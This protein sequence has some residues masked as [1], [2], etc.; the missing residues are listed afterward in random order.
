[1]A[2]TEY[3]RPTISSEP[4]RPIPMANQGYPYNSIAS[5]RRYEELVYSIHKKKVENEKTWKELYDDIALM[6]GVG[7]KGR[8][9]VLYKDGII[10]GLIQCKKYE[11]RISKPDCL[12][13]ILKFVLYSF[14][15]PLVL[16][17]PNHFTYYFVVSEGFSG[18]AADYL[19]K[20]ND[21]II[22]EPEL[23]NW[24]NELKSKYN[25]SLGSLDYKTIYAD[26]LKKLAAIKVRKVVP[27]DLDIELSAPYC[28]SIIPIFFE[29][30]T[31]T[32]NSRIDQLIN[33]IRLGLLRQMI[34][35]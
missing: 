23:E 8:D 12:K 28:Q 32:D 18:P 29:V 16:P 6:Q 22:K 7:E 27:Q 2:S 25:A 15:D 33:L 30:R 21:E 1:M 5:A 3:S 9:C 26:L 13:E 34:C 14:F 17:D 11:N 35:R 19:D 24:F 31:V 4:G 20:F 10:K